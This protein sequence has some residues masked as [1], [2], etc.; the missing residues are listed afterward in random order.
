MLPDCGAT[1]P[2]QDCG[3]MWRLQSGR[4][5]PMVPLAG[6]RRIAV[7][8]IACA[9][10]GASGGGV[11]TSADSATRR[12]APGLCTRARVTCYKLRK[13]TNAR[14]RRASSC[15]VHAATGTYTNNSMMRSEPTEA[16]WGTKRL[17]AGC[18]LSV[19]QRTLWTSVRRARHGQTVS[20]HVQ[21]EEFALRDC[22][23]SESKGSG[24]GCGGS[25]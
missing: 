7:T 10:S 14:H 25:P 16:A 19:G 21:S 3:A 15:R 12:L 9:G 6:C 24:Q 23:A 22:Q 20:E 5:C 13:H 2:L 8:R 11:R 17:A 1:R 4:K 18:T